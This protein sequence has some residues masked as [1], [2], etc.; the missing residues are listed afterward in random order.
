MVAAAEDAAEEWTDWYADA[1]RR[2]DAAKAQQLAA[3]EAA[4]QEWRDWYAAT[5]EQERKHPG[6]EREPVSWS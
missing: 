5:H 6:R 4:E 3:A 1:R 2:A